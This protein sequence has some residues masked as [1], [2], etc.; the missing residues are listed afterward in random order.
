MCEQSPP[1]ADAG[2]RFRYGYYYLFNINSDLSPQ[3]QKRVEFRHL[4][5][6]TSHEAKPVHEEQISARTSV[7][8]RKRPAGRR[9]KLEPRSHSETLPVRHGDTYKPSHARR[10][11]KFGVQGSRRS[12]G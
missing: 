3:S 10:N 1:G 8:Y 4:G 7:R 2:G 11:L 9:R 12:C 6:G 5:W